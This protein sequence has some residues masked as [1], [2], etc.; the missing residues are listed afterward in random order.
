MP[1][2][3]EQDSELGS[4]RQ[5]VSS[6]NWRVKS[7]ESKTLENDATP[8]FRPHQSNETADLERSSNPNNKFGRSH[9]GTKKDQNKS[10]ECQ[11]NSSNPSNKEVPDQSQKLRRFYAQDLPFRTSKPLKPSVPDRQQLQMKTFR[12]IIRNQNPLFDFSNRDKK[13]KNFPLKNTKPD[14]TDT[15]VETKK[16]GVGEYRVLNLSKRPE[17]NQK[18]QKGSDNLSGDIKLDRHPTFK[19]NTNYQDQNE[20]YTNM[21]PTIQSEQIKVAEG[22]IFLSICSKI[23]LSI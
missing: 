11:S 9:S 18:P 5:M 3:Q 2:I 4:T 12:P 7:P 6:N 8:G 23:L 15:K 17:S 13:N 10:S 19:P 22:I 21:S 1:I 16:Q 20:Y 14:T